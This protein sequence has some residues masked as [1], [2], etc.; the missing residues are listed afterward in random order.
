MHAHD[1]WVEHRYRLC[2]D[3]SEEEAPLFNV[4]LTNGT[5]TAR[6]FENRD[7]VGCLEAAFLHLQRWKGEYKRLSYGG[8]TMLAPAD[9]HSTS[10]RAPFTTDYH[11][12]RF[13]RAQ[14]MA[15][16]L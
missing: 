10:S 9:C 13:Y 6:R 4:M 16:P 15:C 1:R 12:T 8:E 2:A 7:P 11:T 3:L 5:W 14:A